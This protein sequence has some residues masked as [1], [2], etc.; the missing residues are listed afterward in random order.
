MPATFPTAFCKPIHRPVARGPAK[1]CV[2]EG[3][4]GLLRPSSAAVRRRIA[5]AA[6]GPE[7]TL[8]ARRQ[9]PTPALLVAS[10]V[11][12]ARLRLAPRETQRSSRKPAASTLAPSTT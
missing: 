5:P 1:V 9:R 3:F 10:A 6:T 8:A 2:T 7:T 12:Y 11:L 4:D